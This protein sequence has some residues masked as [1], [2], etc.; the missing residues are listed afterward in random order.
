MRSVLSPARFALLV[1]SVAVG[2]AESIGNDTETSSMVTPTSVQRD[3]EGPLIPSPRVEISAEP[4]SSQA[5]TPTQQTQAE[6]RCPHQV[7][8]GTNLDLLGDRALLFHFSGN[9]APT[10]IWAVSGTGS[11]P[12]Q[13]VETGP[14]PLSRILISPHGSYLAWRDHAENELRLYGIPGHIMNTLSWQSEWQDLDLWTADGMLR[15]VLGI[16]FEERQGIEIEF[17]LLNPTSFEMS[18]HKHEYDLPGYVGPFFGGFASVSPDDTRVL[19]RGVLE[20]TTSII[21]RDLVGGENFWVLGDQGYLLAS[22]WTRD[23]QQ[24]AVT[25]RRGDF[26]QVFSLT[27]EGVL[28]PL[29]QE[30]IDPNNPEGYVIHDLSWS[31]D[32]NHLFLTLQEPDGFGGYVLQTATGKAR[33]L[34][35]DPKS[36]LSG[37]S[38]A[39]SADLLLYTVNSDDDQESV[40]LLDVDAWTSHLLLQSKYPLSVIGWASL[41]AH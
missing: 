14:S 11:G 40:Y 3:T 13:V 4:T 22:P 29:T 30:P 17:A 33:P 38:W 20:G 34:C 37:F 8:D 10:G 2:C 18:V 23:S 26:M 1:L 12:V 28:R 16:E 39:Y 9:G 27:R 32:G 21:L 19:Y 5:L 36:T 7:P 25:L 41:T 24:V 31:S 15:I 6:S 35:L